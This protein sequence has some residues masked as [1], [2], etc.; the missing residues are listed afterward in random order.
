MTYYKEPF[1]T[2]ATE[3]DCEPHQAI[4]TLYCFDIADDCCVD[5][6]A[7]MSKEN[8]TYV[9]HAYLSETDDI[10]TPDIIIDK[11]INTAKTKIIEQFESNKIYQRKDGHYA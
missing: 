8:N 1:L 11:C 2:E 10:N 6:I 4:R 5:I 7:K 3:L 9:A